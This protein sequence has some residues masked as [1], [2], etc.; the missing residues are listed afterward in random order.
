MT[1]VGIGEAL[2]DCFPERRVLGGAPLNLAFHAHQLLSRLGSVGTVVSR[3][4]EDQLGDELLAELRGRNILTRHIQRDRERP[5]GRVQ[6]TLCSEQQATYEILE[7]AAWDYLEFS[8]ELRQLAASC[9]AVCF[10]TLAQRHPKSRAT[11]AGFLAA[12]P[13]ALRVYDVNLRQAFYSA[14]IVEQ[15]CRSASLVKLNEHEL[16]EVHRLLKLSDDDGDADQQARTM[17]KV[18]RLEGLALTRGALGTVLYTSGERIE[19]Q[20]ISYPPQI[21]ADSVGAGDAC[22]AGLVV[23]LLLG[24]DHRRCVQFANAMG[25]FVASRPGATP[26]LPEE[27]IGQ[28]SSSEHDADR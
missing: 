20:P 15:S 25:A 26:V 3:I 27:L 16:P 17:I 12:A 18:F 9:Q 1:L 22:C 23:G 4:G 6:V 14:E 2:F 24:W 8:D 19:G 5:T 21:N 7:D 28:I 13:Q 10:G 11:I